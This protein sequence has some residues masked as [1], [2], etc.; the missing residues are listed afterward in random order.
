MAAAIL[1]ACQGPAANSG[2]RR[3]SRGWT[4]KGSPMTGGESAALRRALQPVDEAF[5]PAR[6]ER[7]PV[8][9]ALGLCVRGAA[10]VD[11]HRRQHLAGEELAQP[12]GH[13]T[14]AV[15]RAVAAR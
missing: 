5:A 7:L 11:H 2:A 8:Q 3:R 9:L 4:A 6:I 15:R 14:R 12:E 10:T 13:M 1:V